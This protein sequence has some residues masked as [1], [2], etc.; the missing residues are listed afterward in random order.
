[1]HDVAVFNDIVFAFKP[2]FS[3]VFSALFAFIIDEIL[4]GDDFGADKA[5]FKIAVDHTG[6]LLGRLRR[7]GLSMP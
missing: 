2:P 4:I 6:R 1:M 3:G 7:P 5:F